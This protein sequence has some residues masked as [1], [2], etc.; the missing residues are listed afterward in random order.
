MTA[1]FNASLMVGQ[2]DNT[3]ICSISR[4]DNLNSTIMYQ[5][6]KNDEIIRTKEDNPRILSLSPLRLSHAGDYICNI[7]VDQYSTLFNVTASAIN[8]QT[9]M[10]QG[11]LQPII[12]M[13]I[14]LTLFQSYQSQIY[15]LLLLLVAL[16][17]SLSMGLM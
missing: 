14:T 9:V 16:A 2:T 12:I 1:N 3:L 13:E 17:I 7:N 8:S 10:I 15:N 5:W 6:T 11:K 4:A